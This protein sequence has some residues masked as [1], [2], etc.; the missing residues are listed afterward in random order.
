MNNYAN[1]YDICDTPV[2]KER[3]QAAPGENF[4]F[5]YQKSACNWLLKY[6]I[7]KACR[8]PQ[9]PMQDVPVYQAAIR[10]AM[11]A[12]Q[13]NWRD[14]DWIKQTF[15]PIADLLD[16]IDKPQFRQRQ[17]LPLSHALPS[18]AQLNTVIER[19][20]QDILRTWRRD[21]N[22][23]Y[24]PVAAQVI[25]SGDDHMNGEN[26]LNVLCG[27]GSFE[28]QN[29]ALLSAL[30]RCFIS[31]SSAR[32]KFI[33]K[34]Y[35]GI[36]E[37]MWLRSCWFTHRTAFYDV[38]FFEHL[39]AKVLKTEGT[40][41]ELQQILPIMENL[42]QFCGVTSREWL[43]TPNKG[44]KHPAITCLPI[45]SEAIYACRLSK[46]DRAIKKDLGFDDF[47]SD[48][49]TT[50]F[51]LSIAKKWLDLVEDR[52][53]EVDAKLLEECRS[54]LDHPWIEI[55]NEYQIGS[56]YTSNP[57][58][59][60]ITKP[61]NYQGAI[62]IW[63]DK[64]FPKPDGSVVKNVVGNEIC[65]GHN[66]D[67]LESIIVNRKQWNALQGENLKTVRRLLD[68]HYETYRSGNFKQESAF[69]YYLPEIY[70]FY[71]G[72]VYDAY[73]TLSEAEK[74]ILDPSGRIDAIRQIALAYCK[75]DLIAYTLNA[76][77]AALAVSALVLLRHESRDDG[78][79]ATALKVIT[80][81]LGEGVKGH[82]F[83]PYEWNKMRHPCRI[84]V[85][86]D[87]STSLF[88]LNAVVN[89]SFYLYGVD[90]N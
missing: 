20:M 62:P 80:D 27:V 79:L 14:A 72:R 74:M 61:L 46:K 11:Q 32:L 34:H 29:A 89:A 54:L 44:I 71:A 78:L 42:L 75:D 49:D 22:N 15:K 65:P 85:G 1:I 67:I 58:T 2:L 23:P 86:S 26:F 7:L 88:V 60:Q 69:Q 82:P 17:P 81:A 56:G 68:F 55:I 38:N 70:V 35:R 13:M 43:V 90:Q 4:K 30:L 24:F 64:P 36:A 73:L 84:I 21:K 6:L 87:V 5:L 25:L 37:K 8:H 50:F 12:S 16:R 59:I 57:P 51:T 48:T 39:L 31:S 53:L 9:I 45:G 63:F 47:A 52:N 10:A 83:L 28:Y 18:Q 33:R 3:P 76:F 77:D 40:D 41:D 66:M 19:C